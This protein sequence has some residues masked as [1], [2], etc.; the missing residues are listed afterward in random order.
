MRSGGNEGPQSMPRVAACRILD[1]IRS[2]NEL[3]QLWRNLAGLKRAI[4]RI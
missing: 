4:K 2:L 1:K 3:T